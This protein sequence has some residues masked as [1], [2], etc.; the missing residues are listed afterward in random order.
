MVY[1][2]LA[3]LCVLILIL[4]FSPFKYE[5]YL[6]NDEKYN[7]KIKAGWLG[8][9]LQFNFSRRSKEP[10]LYELYVLYKLRAGSAKEYQAWLDQKV[11]D[12]LS[13]TKTEPELESESAENSTKESATPEDK[14]V[15]EKASPK[16]KM[17]NISEVLGIVL[18]GDL[19]AALIKM[20]KRMYNHS[21]P[22]HCHIKGIIG[23]GDP[24]YTAFLQSF[25][26]YEW[27]EMT[28]E[29]EFDY[30][31]PVCKGSFTMSGKIY[32]A[33]MAW[34]GLCFVGAK[35]VRQT[36]KKLIALGRKGGN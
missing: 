28:D 16:R 24:A 35:P 31:E 18:N 19:F 11:K 29:I 22:R 34:Y 6:E 5:I 4:L 12:E 8:K 2:L 15:E 36:I 30:L 25:L 13:E 3:T 23:T 10:P 33:F 7:I 14:K 21:K 20:L 26:Y 1:V 9:I 17:P 27:H 32:P